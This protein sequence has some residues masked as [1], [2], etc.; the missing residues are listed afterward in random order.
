M[1]ANNQSENYT[2]LPNTVAGKV[3]YSNPVNSQ[4]SLYYAYDV[5]AVY[6][7]LFMN[8]R[9]L[10]YVNCLCMLFAMFMYVKYNQMLSFY[11]KFYWAVNCRRIIFK[12]NCINCDGCVF[13]LWEGERVGE[14]VEALELCLRARDRQELNC[15][16]PVYNSVAAPHALQ[17]NGMVAYTSESRVVCAAKSNSPTPALHKSCLPRA[18]FHW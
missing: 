10:P 2:F 13:G 8:C 5:C 7:S 15:Y 18:K 11:I 16:C 4:C 14:G 1:L 6:F 12:I 9:L 17:D 3:S